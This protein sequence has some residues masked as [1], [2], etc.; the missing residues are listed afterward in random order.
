[1]NK[2]NYKELS[3]VVP[4]YN[5]EEIL[6]ETIEIF[7]QDLSSV[8]DKYEI[9]IINDGSTDTTAQIADE[10]AR[11]NESIKVIHNPK[12]LG[13]GKSLLIGFKSA[14]YGLVLT[15]FAD[16]PFDLKELKNIFSFFDD[17]N[18]DFVVVVRKD[19]S[20]NS[21]YRKITSLIN[22]WLIRML[23]GVKVGD[24]QFVQIYKKVILD[25]IEVDATQTFVPPEL[26]IKA[27]SKGYRMKEYKSKFHSRVKGKSKCGNPGV[28]S[29]TLYDMLKFWWH[30]DFKK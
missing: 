10:L 17:E 20:A 1:M 26:I 29:K 25:D 23:F 30:F 3:L 16:R 22:Y 28:I 2:M 21:A 7:L 19:R 24:Y 14:K 15:N 9:I 4:A 13:S 11:R 18:T 6:A 12:N 8:A 27:L 5:E